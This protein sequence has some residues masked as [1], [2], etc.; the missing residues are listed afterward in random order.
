M[1]YNKKSRSLNLAKETAHH[2]NMKSKRMSRTK[3]SIGQHIMGFVGKLS[4]ISVYKVPA[5]FSKKSIVT[6]TAHVFGKTVNKK[7]YIK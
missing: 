5:K 6:K 3:K 2:A 4:P 7:G 1:S